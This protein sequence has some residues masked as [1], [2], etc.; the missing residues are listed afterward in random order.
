MMHCRSRVY[1]TQSHTLVGCVWCMVHG[2]GE[3]Q[4]WLDRCRSDPALNTY[5]SS[6]GALQQLPAD[7]N[8]LQP[9]TLD[10]LRQSVALSTTITNTNTN[11]SSSRSSSSSRRGAA[12]AAAAAAA[13]GGVRSGVQGGDQGVGVGQQ[14]VSGADD[15]WLQDYTHMHL[16][17]VC[18]RAA[19]SYMHCR[20]NNC[21]NNNRGGPSCCVVKCYRKCS[22]LVFSHQNKCYWNSNAAVLASSGLMTVGR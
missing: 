16:V 2:A 15:A 12:A 6:T 22:R 7:V 21:G 1:L 19:H 20:G 3:L 9:H 8:H 5:L 11:T 13:G 4:S 10:A 14:V 17:S 18:V